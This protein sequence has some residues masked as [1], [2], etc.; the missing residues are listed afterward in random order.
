MFDWSNRLSWWIMMNPYLYNI[1]SNLKRKKNNRRNSEVIYFPKFSIIWSLEHIMLVLIANTAMTGRYNKICN[2]FPFLTSFNCHFNYFCQTSPVKLV[3]LKSDRGLIRA[4]F[5]N[6]KQD[7]SD[8]DG[9]QWTTAGTI[10]NS[11]RY[12][13]W[14]YR[15]IWKG[16]GNSITFMFRLK[17]PQQMISLKLH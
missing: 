3:N 13:Q 1:S 15:I 16:R 5:W 17:M 14:N 9:S 6:L 12:S 10:H 8:S 2:H 4:E 11:L 7:N